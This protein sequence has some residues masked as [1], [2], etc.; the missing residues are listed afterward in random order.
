M[1]ASFESEPLN[2][3]VW[4]WVS[5][6]FFLSFLIPLFLFSPFLNFLLFL[7]SSQCLVSLSFSPSFSCQYTHHPHRNDSWTL[8]HKNTHTAGARALRR[9][10]LF[11]HSISDHFW[12]TP[13]SKQNR[14]V[15]SLRADTEAQQADGSKGPRA[16]GAP[17][18][19]EL[20]LCFRRR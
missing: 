14:R 16:S 4:S 15:F 6:S 7:F 2:R 9:A 1:Q 11:F 13:G 8:T 12:R 20:L 5:F 17:S 10:L 3:A 19:T 18:S